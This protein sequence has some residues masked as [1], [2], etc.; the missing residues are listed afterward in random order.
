M[1][2]GGFGLK[3]Y[4]QGMFLIRPKGPSSLKCPFLYV[5]FATVVLLGAG[6]EQPEPVYDDNLGL[7]AIAGEKG[8]LAGTFAQKHS[9]LS[10][11]DLPVLGE[12]ENGGESYLLVTRTWNSEEEKYDQQSRKLRLPS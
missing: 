12:Q 4:N 3:R 1:W 8:S 5:I 7:Q 9:I 6:C 11:S 10:V 2:L